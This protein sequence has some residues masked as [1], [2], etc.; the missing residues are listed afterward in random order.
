MDAYMDAARGRVTAGQVFTHLSLYNPFTCS[1]E[2][3]SFAVKDGTVVG[4]GEGYEGLE[5][6]DLKGARVVPGLIDAHAHIESSMLSPGEYA[7][8][9]LPRGTTTVVADPHEIANVSG[10]EGIEF[11]LAEGARSPL[12]VK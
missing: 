11:I 5:T 9:V 10:T 7:R 1:W 2:E 12:S 3:T 6:V 4:M 8:V